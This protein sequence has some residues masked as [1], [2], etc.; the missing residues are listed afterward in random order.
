MR[1]AFGLCLLGFA[2]P[3]PFWAAA[4]AAA[5]LGMGSDAMV[6]GCETALVDLAGDDLPRQLARQNLLGE[7]GDLLGPVLLAAV[8][9][10]GLPWQGAFWVGAAVAFAFAGL[11]AALPLPPPSDA[12]GRPPGGSRRGR[13]RA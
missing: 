6:H 8:V 11:L 13:H 1:S 7:V 2:L 9:A 3:L 12:R 4:I 10:A 5:G